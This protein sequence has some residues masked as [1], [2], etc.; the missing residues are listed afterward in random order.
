MFGQLTVNRRYQRLARAFDRIADVPGDVVVCSDD[1]QILLMLQYL[2]E[3]EA[4]DRVDRHL[5]AVRT[6]TSAGPIAFLYGEA[7]DTLRAQVA[8]GGVMVRD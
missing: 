3:L 8:Q 7:P 5:R 1:Q 2:A 6:Q 4:Q